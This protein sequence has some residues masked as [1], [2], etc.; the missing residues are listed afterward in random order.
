MYEG[1]IFEV[2]IVDSSRDRVRLSTPGWTLFEQFSAI[3]IIA[4]FP[5]GALSVDARHRLLKERLMD[6]S[7]QVRK[8]REDTRFLFSM[9]HFTAF[10]RSACENFSEERSFD[11]IN[12]SRLYTPVAPDLEEHSSNFL[13]HIKSLKELTGFAAPMLASSFFLDSYPPDAHRKLLNSITLTF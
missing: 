5:A 6:G 12:A 2:L 7:D 11:F 10:F 13:K 1:E 3:E 8:G 9:T 4:L